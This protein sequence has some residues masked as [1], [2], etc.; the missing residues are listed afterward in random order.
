MRY[1]KTISSID[2]RTN[3]RATR[4]AWGDT[5]WFF[6]ALVGDGFYG[7]PK[8]LTLVRR[9]KR[10]LSIKAHAISSGS[11]KFFALI[12]ARLK[13]QMLISFVYI[14]PSTEFSIY[15]F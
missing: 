12:A 13:L 10:V 9:L 4:S 8:G 1:S 7:Y 2:R 6:S 15:I 5:V 11:R 14:L 3:E